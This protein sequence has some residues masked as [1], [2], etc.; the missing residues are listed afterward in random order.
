V[1]DQPLFAVGDECPKA[2]LEELNERVFLG[3]P[4]SRSATD[5]NE[6]QRF[7]IPPPRK[8]H[9]PGK[10]KDGEKHVCQLYLAK[11]DRI[12]STVISTSFSIS[13]IWKSDRTT[14]TTSEPK[15]PT[16]QKRLK[17]AEEEDRSEPV[18]PTLERILTPP[19]QIRRLNR[20]PAVP[21]APKMHPDD[22]QTPPEQRR[23]LAPL[24]GPFKE[25]GFHPKL[26]AQV[27]HFTNAGAPNSLAT[28]MGS[29]PHMSSVPLAFLPVSS[30]IPSAIRTDVSLGKTNP[31]MAFAAKFTSAIPAGGRQPQQPFP[32]MTRTASN[33]NITASTA[34]GDNQLPQ[35]F[36]G[37]PGAGF[38][39]TPLARGGGLGGAMT[40][41]HPTMTE[42]AARHHQQQSM[43]MPPGPGPSTTNGLVA[44]RPMSILGPQGSSMPHE[45]MMRN[46]TMST[47][48]MP[49]MMG[50]PITHRLLV[51]IQ[52]TRMPPPPVAQQ[53]H[54]QQTGAMNS[55]QHLA[56]HRQGFTGR[57]GS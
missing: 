8:W 5:N 21:V 14:A 28:T 22:I 36:Q 48:L 12:V 37:F 50:P 26:S 3:Q 40:I 2:A 49:P 47:P 54:L 19:N 27:H 11:H 18:P 16:A 10:L 35:R 43:M 44:Y 13:P 4:M 24:P 56:Q 51:P 32:Q 53:L 7:T 33:N 34:H 45:A 17:L 38:P 55:L 9:Y 42:N 52:P 29:G 41:P 46:P 1:S 20:V 25:E 39:V 31:A 57:S 30:T 23:R 15:K 6:S